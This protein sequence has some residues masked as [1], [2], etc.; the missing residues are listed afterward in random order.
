MIEKSR[1]LIDG[2]VHVYDSFDLIEFFTRACTHLDYFYE[3]KYAN[4]SPYEKLLLLTEAGNN[5]F[6]ARWR[7]H[8]RLGLNSGFQ[9]KETGEE[10]SLILEKDSVPQ[11]YIL[12]GRQIV[13]A[14]GLEVLAVGSTLTIPDGLPIQEVIQTIINQEE[15][16]VLA[17][18]FGKWLFRR[19]KVIQQLIATNDSPY[20]LLGDNSGRP[21]FW[22]TPRLY[23][24]G[25]A[26]NTVLTSGSD[27]LPFPEE[28]IKV[29]TFGFS[30]EAQF[31]QN[32]P[33]ASLRDILISPGISS[34]IDYF[35][36]RDGIVSFFTRQS[37][38]YLK[39]YF[40]K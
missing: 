12:R 15:L 17:W 7:E 33:A 28:Y 8:G 34:N 10:A 27:P 30:L 29:G 13:T 38:I 24:Q 37:K 6:F 26:V 14:E 19:G 11:C 1:L 9:F 20:L 25:R 35:G 39:K 31:D 16:A 32:K 21:V 36:Y 40:K 23:K 4:G 5:D 18:G 3:K 22:G 2:H